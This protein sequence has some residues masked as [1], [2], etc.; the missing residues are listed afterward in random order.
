MAWIVYLNGEEFAR[1]ERREDLPVV[2]GL[3]GP[4][5]S[6]GAKGA[7]LQHPSSSGSTIGWEEFPS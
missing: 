5:T 7:T 2:L 4:G 1:I 3:E 6:C